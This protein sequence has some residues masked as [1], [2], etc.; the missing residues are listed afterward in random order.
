MKIMKNRGPR[1]LP[2]GTPDFTVKLREREPHA[3]TNCF[4]SVKY[5]TESMQESCR[6]IQVYVFFLSRACDLLYQKL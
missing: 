3:L 6:Q 4:R 5:M 1:W 2:W